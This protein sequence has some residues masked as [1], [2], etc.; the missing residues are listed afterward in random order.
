ML[1]EKISHIDQAEPALQKVMRAY[2]AVYWEQRNDGAV[3]I[4]R[5]MRQ[6]TNERL[7]VDLQKL[8]VI[9]MRL[10]ALRRNS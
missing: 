1:E 2:H 4:N 9:R 6:R 5:P 8:A 3:F 7:E 10:S